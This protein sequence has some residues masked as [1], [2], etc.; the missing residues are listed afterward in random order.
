MFDGTLGTYTG[1]TYKIELQDKNVKPFHA[2]A[3]PIPRVHEATLKKEVERLIKI[4]VL[5]ELIIHNGQ[6]PPLLFQRKMEQSD[7]Y[8]T[9]GN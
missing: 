2:R 4:G 7:L 3:Y 6:R 9:L 1:S 8:P 5:R